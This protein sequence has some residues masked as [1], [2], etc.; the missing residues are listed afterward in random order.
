MRIT[1]M[2]ITIEISEPHAGIYLASLG[3]D[4]VVA[5]L[6]ATAAS[7][8]ASRL[9]MSGSRRCR[10]RGRTLRLGIWRPSYPSAALGRKCACVRNH[11]AC[12]PRSVV[13]VR[14]VM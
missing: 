13:N 1:P 10:R 14:S 9:A 5:H 4:R 2:T 8:S 6:A 7:K 12:R 3:P 11:M